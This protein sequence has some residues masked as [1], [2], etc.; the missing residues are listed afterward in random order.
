MPDRDG[1]RSQPSHCD[2]AMSAVYG[3][4][5]R[6]T[7]LKAAFATFCEPFRCSKT[8]EKTCKSARFRGCKPAFT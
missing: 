1:A 4:A 7:G 3:I 6:D 5:E 2:R 8:E